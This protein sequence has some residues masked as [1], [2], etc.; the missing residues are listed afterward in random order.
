MSD[1]LMDETTG[2]EMLQRE[3]LRAYVQLHAD[4]LTA[5]VEL[6]LLPTEA[7]HLYAVLETALQSGELSRTR[8]TQLRWVTERLARIVTDDPLIRIE[9]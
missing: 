2:D 4:R 3:A 8:R 6:K 7:V 5:P 9:D 1:R